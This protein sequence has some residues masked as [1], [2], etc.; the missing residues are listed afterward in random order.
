MKK[1]ILSVAL[2]AVFVLAMSACAEKA[3]EPVADVSTEISEEVVTSVS[4]VKN[5]DNQ[6]YG[7]TKS[8]VCILKRKKDRYS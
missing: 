2:P 1:K 3:P 8:L 7:S 6:S 4:A 5:D